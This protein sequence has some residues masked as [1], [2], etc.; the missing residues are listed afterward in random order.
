VG[1]GVVRYVTLLWAG[2]TLQIVGGWIGPGIVSHSHQ[3]RRVIILSFR[4]RV[5]MQHL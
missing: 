1:H 2:S 4:I 3:L 5:E